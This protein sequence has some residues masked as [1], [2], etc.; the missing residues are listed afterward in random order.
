MS[1][2]PYQPP[3][4]AGWPAPPPKKPKAPLFLGMLIGAVAPFF[5]LLVPALFSGE[6][7]AAADAV[8]FAPFVWVMVIL[9]T[10][11]GLLFS[12]R[13]RRWGVGI[14]IGLF[15]ML[16]I[17]AGVCVAALVVILSAYNGG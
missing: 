13:T 1:Q 8:A 12:D 7:G 3:P 2:P 5:G 6:P 9:A 16:I 15:G 4:G 10:G 11:A 14:L 17:G